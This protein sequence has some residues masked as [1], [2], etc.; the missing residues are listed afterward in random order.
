LP[1]V[2]QPTAEL[3]VR[4]TARISAALFA[5]ALIVFAAGY[6]HDQRRLYVAKRLFAGFIVAHTVH[7]A[8]V[9][10][11]AVVTSG[12]NIRERDGWAFVLTVALL[13]YAAVF[14][15]V[16]AWGNAAMG[17]SPRSLRMANVAIV[18]IA[19]VFLNSYL[20]RVAEMPIYWLLTIGLAG[21]VAFYFARIGRA[22]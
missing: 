10:W 21:T 11:L 18:A 7:F 19:A 6:Q 4:L 9:A 14:C 5:A 22:A 2:D 17:S 8:T 16:R 20:T 15:V 12:E 13:F 3:L 1:P